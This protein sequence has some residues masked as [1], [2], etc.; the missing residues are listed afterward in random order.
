LGNARLGSLYCYVGDFNT[1]HFNATGAVRQVVFLPANS[2]A[3]TLSNY[4]NITS[5][6]TTTIQKFDTMGAYLRTYPGDVQKITFHEWSNLDK[7]PNGIKTNY[8]QQVYST[9]TSAYAGQQMILQF[10]AQT[11]GS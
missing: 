3:I 4:L 11:D 1:T 7:D 10:Y 8:T 9:N 6:E 2:T 5:Q